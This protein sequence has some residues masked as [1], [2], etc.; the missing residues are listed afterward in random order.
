VR[1][2]TRSSTIWLNLQPKWIASSAKLGMLRGRWLWLAAK[3]QTKPRGT[4]VRQHL[5][6]EYKHSLDIFDT[7][8]TPVL[9]S[10]T[11]STAWSFP[12]VAVV[13]WPRNFY[14]Y[15]TEDAK[16]AIRQSQKTLFLSRQPLMSVPYGLAL[17][18]QRRNIWHW[19]RDDCDWLH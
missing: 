10:R 1:R 15:G 11:E 7:R 16:K 13:Y 18:C 9:F 8:I 4:Q 19:Q 6:P 2:T 17:K 12:V 3:S 14:H 5:V